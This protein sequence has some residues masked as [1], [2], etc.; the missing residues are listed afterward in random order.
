MKNLTYILS[1]FLLL[2]SFSACEKNEGDN[3]L[4]NTTSPVVSPLGQTEWVLDKPELGDDIFLFRINWTKARFTYP[5]GDPACVYNVIY[6][7]Q[8][9]L[10]DN[11][12]SQAIVLEATDKLYADIYA[13]QLF[14]ILVSLT[15]NEHYGLQN[16]AIRV[17]TEYPNGEVVYSNEIL[18][19][20]KEPAPINVRWTITGGSWAEMAVYVWGDSD[21]FGSWPG[22]VVTPDA[23][24]WYAITVPYKF[25]ANVIIN[26]NGNGEQLDLVSIPALNAQD[27]D[28]YVNLE[29]GDVYTS[30]PVTVTW[31]IVA[32]SWAD[33]YVYAWGDNELFG[34]WPGRELTANIDGSFSVAVPSEGEVNLIIN[35]DA[36]DQVNLISN[37]TDNVTLYVDLNSGDVST[38]PKV[39]KW[40]VVNGSWADMYVYSW[41][42]DNNYHGAW[43]GKLLTPDVYGW[44]S[45]SIAPGFDQH[46]IINNNAGSQHDMPYPTVDAQYE[47]DLTAGTFV[48]AT[49]WSIT[50]RWTQPADEW[51]GQMAI[52][53]WGGNPNSDTFGGWPGQVVA[54][55]MS[56]WYSVTV[57]P[58]QTVGN[59]ILNNNSGGQQFDINLNITNDVCLEITGSGF[60]MVTCD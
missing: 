17:K 35:N 16:L 54:A 21:L 33:M 55:D 29:T 44:Y 30:R 1:I 22:E 8:I 26:N 36:G 11:Q 42:T 32:G 34:S 48:Q 53:A 58:G 57:P 52:Y 15:G 24:G 31:I 6:T 19:T 14:D 27:V 4:F 50:I 40:K 10:A 25:N 2:I 18:F 20:V 43:P 59:A 5:S 41:G 45:V 9:D 7:A 12:F 56:G 51:S 49:E 38:G 13:E 28:L 37:P 23:D 60:S 3:G 39:V 46:L 47:V